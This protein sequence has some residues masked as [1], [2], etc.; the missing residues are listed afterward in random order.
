[1]VAASKADKQTA[2]KPI[3]KGEEK[4]NSKKEASS[5][6]SEEEA[7]QKRPKNRHR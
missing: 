4:K 3:R 5:H 2:R 1:M 7:C 6:V